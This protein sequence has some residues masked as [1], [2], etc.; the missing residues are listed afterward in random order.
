MSRLGGTESSVQTRLPWLRGHRGTLEIFSHSQIAFI[1]LPLRPNNFSSLYELLK[2]PFS[3][4]SAHFD[5]RTY[6]TQYTTLLAILRALQYI[7]SRNILLATVSTHRYPPTTHTF[8]FVSLS[9]SYPTVFESLGYK[10]PQP[11]SS[12]TSTRPRRYDNQ[13]SS[14]FDSFFGSIHPTN[15]T[16]RQPLDQ[17]VLRIH[18]KVESVHNKQ[19]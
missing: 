10:A 5:L 7:V 15:N 16:F 14:N 1:Y 19:P 8:E 11:T 4:Y 6:T 13:R 2:K 17:N 18:Q 3:T 12:T 9:R